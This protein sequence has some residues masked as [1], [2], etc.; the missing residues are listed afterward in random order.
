MASKSYAT[1]MR[2]R[3]RCHFV[4]G[5]IH[6]LLASFGFDDADLTELQ[7]DKTRIE[8][9]GAPIGSR[10]AVPQKVLAQLIVVF[11]LGL[12]PA[13][14]QWQCRPTNRRAPATRLQSHVGLRS[15]SSYGV[16][17]SGAGVTSFSISSTGS[18]TASGS[19]TSRSPMAELKT[20]CSDHSIPR[21]AP[22][23]CPAK[24]IELC[25]RCE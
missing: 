5:L 14:R 15:S 24:C 23:V 2:F 1:A 10:R 16:C 18:S 4:F 12:Y 3:C 6:G 21:Q 22:T 7:C 25:C 13:M 8:I 20:T 9:I 19:K 17:G 11:L